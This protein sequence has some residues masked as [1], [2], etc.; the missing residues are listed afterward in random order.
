MDSADAYPTFL[1]LAHDFVGLAAGTSFIWIP[2]VFFA[3]AIGRKSVGL[4][5]YLIFT[6]SEAIAVLLAIWIYHGWWP[7][8]WFSL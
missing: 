3:F 1:N 4:W 5:F 6:A 7:P 2:L 8:R